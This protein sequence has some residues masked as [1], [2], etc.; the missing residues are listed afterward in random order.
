MTPR[1]QGKHQ[2]EVMAKLR[3]QPQNSYPLPPGT[4][5]EGI[6]VRAAI[7]RLAQK[8]LAVIE[9]DRYRIAR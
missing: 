9:G 2:R 8:G 5:S 3:R 6:A 1:P 7:R 4:D